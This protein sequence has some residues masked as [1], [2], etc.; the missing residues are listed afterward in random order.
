MKIEGH[1]PFSEGTLSFFLPDG[2]TARVVSAAQP[3][4]MAD[5]KALTE[6]ALDAPRGSPTLERL[7]GSIKPRRVCIAFTDATRACPD[8]LLAPAILHRLE[9]AG[10]PASAVTLLC[11]LGLHRGSTQSERLAK[12]GDT[13]LDRYH[14]VDHHARDQANV[15]HLGHTANDIPLTV[16]R[17]AHEADLLIATGIVEPHQ[18]AGYSGGAKT[19]SIGCGGEQTIAAT[20]G[21]EMLDQPGVRLGRIEDNPFQVA[22]RQAAVQAGLQFVLNV[23]QDE[24]RRILKVAA[25]APAAVH[26]HLVAF[27]RQALEVHVPHQYDLAVA[28]VGAPKDVNLYQASRAIT[29]LQLTANPV[30]RPGGIL[31]LPAPCPEG[32]GEGVGEQRFLTALRDAPDIPTMLNHMR[33]H[34]Y[35][36]G[37]QRAFVLGK[38][39]ANNDVIVVGAQDPQIVRDCKMM[40]AETME[41]AFEMATRKLGKP[42][43][44]LIVPHA[45]QILVRVT[46]EK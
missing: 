28:G 20:H 37:A 10:V 40:P 31:I 22:V 42:L 3:M 27:A 13:I 11:A 24:S 15:V 12:L 7:V 46:D 34:G 6:A 30:V 16:N 35:P 18:Y 29:Y 14:V 33:T 44:L 8:H 32:A 43:D 36:P 41:Q 9:A 25:G 2:V 45:L 38:V 23:I 5:P 26:D 17:V 21:P 4:P 39:L 1:I 19:I